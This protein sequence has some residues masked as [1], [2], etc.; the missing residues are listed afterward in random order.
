MCAIR[1]RDGDLLVEFRPG[2]EAVV[3]DDLAHLKLEFSVVVA[4]REGR[5]LLVY[6]PW[7]KEWEL[8]AGS[9]EPGEAPSDAARRELAE[10]SGQRAAALRCI[11]LLL[12]HIQRGNRLELGAV[13]T[14]QIESLL[15]FQP[16]DEA[17]QMLWWDR[18]S[19]VEGH[20]NEIAAA[21]CELVE[22]HL[23]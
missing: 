17:A 15:P 12:L 16:N 13:Y 9:I 6:N 20:L 8:P 19:P 7:R 10:E 21:L 11:G 14:S 22:G 3:P 4:K 18:Q 23:E 2:V 1:S 5:V